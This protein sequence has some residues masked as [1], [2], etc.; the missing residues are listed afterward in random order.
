MPSYGTHRIPSTVW[1]DMAR[2]SLSDD[3]RQLY[4]YL[5]TSP[6]RTYPALYRL[7]PAY[8]AADLGWPEARVLAALEALEAAELVEYDAAAQ[9][10]YVPA[11]FRAEC[12]G[13]NRRQAVG[14]LRQLTT[15]PRTPLLWSLLADA[16]RWAPVLAELLRGYL[17]AGHVDP[18]TLSH[19]LS[20]S[21]SDTLSGPSAG[22][23]P[24]P[25]AATPAAAE[26]A[27]AAGTSGDSSR[28]YARA[29]AHA[30]AKIHEP[31][32]DI[33]SSS[34]A[35]INAAAA[36]V[37]EH[38]NA[39]P[40]EE[41]APWERWYAERHHGLLPGRAYRDRINQL[42][43]RGLEDRVVIAALELAVERGATYPVAYACHVLVD[44][45][46]ERGVRTWYDWQRLRL[47]ERA[48]SGDAAAVAQLRSGR[49]A[50]PPEQQAEH[51]AELR[52]RM[53]ELDRVAEAL[54]RGEPC[55]WLDDRPENPPDFPVTE[56][57]AEPA[58][59]W[60]FILNRLRNAKMARPG[61]GWAH[62]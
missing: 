26:S 31:C 33:T 16:A 60:T 14:A 51:Q 23:R 10:V 11:A 22:P 61:E 20:D 56:K 47:S 59:V 58:T 5:W 29:H 46:E 4:L 24:G 28:A 13:L 9:A 43:A 57:S 37:C 49:L 18:D 44:A 48:R 45:Y 2:R 6:H 19:S 25:A 42:R 1:V 21:L 30:R 39:G 17:G 15:I 12:A 40:A 3:A 36:E 62:A 50:P 34:A 27:C 52:R 35:S 54:A 38:E 41:L 7:P 55:P 53:A 8:A 32:R